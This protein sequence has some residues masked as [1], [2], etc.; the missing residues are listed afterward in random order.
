[1]KFPKSKR[2]DRLKFFLGEGLVTSHGEKW[3]KHRHIINP[4]FHFEALRN[5]I[6]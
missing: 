2:Y 4:S 6:T 5:I 1:M 3:Q